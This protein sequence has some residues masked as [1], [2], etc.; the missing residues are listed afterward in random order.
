[1]VAQTRQ[2]SVISLQAGPSEVDNSSL[3]DANL[4]MNVREIRAIG[5]QLAEIGDRL[6]RE[7][8]ERSNPA[9]WPPALLM[10][11]PAQALTRDIYRGIRG[12]FWGIRSWSAVM[13]AC[14]VGAW[15]SQDTLS[16][17]AWAAWVSS[18]QHVNCTGW[19]TR[20][21]V[22]VALVATATICTAFWEKWKG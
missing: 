19:S 5:Q 6:N 2:S 13:K 15:A 1:M 17:E 14:G 16:A 7:W 20:V 8:A 9:Q 4:R 18:I 3:F 22:A 21:L 11:R 12:P 10:A